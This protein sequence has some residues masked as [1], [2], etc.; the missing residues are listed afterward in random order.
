MVLLFSHFS[1][2]LSTHR[3]CARHF[4]EPV[5][6]VLDFSLVFV[7]M[8]DALVA[9]L[10]DVLSQ[11]FQLTPAEK[12]NCHRVGGFVLYWSCLPLQMIHTKILMNMLFHTII[13][14]NQNDNISLAPNNK[15][16][17]TCP[18]IMYSLLMYVKYYLNL[19]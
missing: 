19:H 16:N 5:M 14:L 12:L 17:K 4:S 10:G 1:N 18:Y 9:S 15:Q 8:I 7:L 11:E 6:R 3:K 13:F 2:T